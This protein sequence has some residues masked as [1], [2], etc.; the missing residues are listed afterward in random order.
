MSFYTGVRTG[1]ASLGG[2]AVASL[3][4]LAPPRFRVGDAPLAL[5]AGLAAVATCAYQ[6]LVRTTAQMY[7][8]EQIFCLWLKS[9]LSKI[10]WYRKYLVT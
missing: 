10:T 2:L 5:L 8:G 6:A 3:L 7:I 1:V 9:C 4:R